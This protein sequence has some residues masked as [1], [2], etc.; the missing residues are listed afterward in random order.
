MIDSKKRM[1]ISTTD[2]VVILRNGKFER[3]IE[4][5]DSI[6]INSTFEDRDGALY[7]STAE[8]VVVSYNNQILKYGVKDGLSNRVVN[9]VNQDENGYIWIATD[10][11]ITLVKS[12]IDKENGEISIEKKEVLLKNK[13][14][15]NIFKNNHQFFIGTYNHG[16]YRYKNRE[17]QQIF[18]RDFTDSDIFTIYGKQ[19]ENIWIGTSKGLMRIKDSTLFFEKTPKLVGKSIKTIFQDSE[20]NIWVGSEKGVHFFTKSKFVYPVYFVKD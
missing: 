7:F 3:S 17:V 14:V 4:E 8:G 9:C 15:Y 18:Q 20:K 13:I 1:W 5:L 10:N 6:H 11:G 16:L 12:S 2:G 19:P